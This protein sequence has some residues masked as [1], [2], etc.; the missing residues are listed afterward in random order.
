MDL[1]DLTVS[2]E[3]SDYDDLSPAFPSTST[4]IT[5]WYAHIHVIV[6]YTYIELY[7]SCIATQ[8]IPL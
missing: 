1:V 4:C 2:S 3:D 8:L 5:D 6:N 7:P